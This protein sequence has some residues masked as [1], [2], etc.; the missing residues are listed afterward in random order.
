MRDRILNFVLYQT[1][2]FAVVLSAAGGK[3]WEGSAVGLVLVGVHLYLS[4]ERGPEI[5]MIL[6]IGIMG[7]VVDSA[8][9][10]AGV[11]VFESGYWTYWIVPFW[12]TV[13]WLQFATLFHFVLA[14]LS[15]RYF[16]SAALGGLGGPAAFLTG[17]KLGGVIFPMGTRYSLLILAGVWAG[18]TPA[19]VFIAD[20][21]RPGGGMGSYRLPKRAVEENHSS[22]RGSEYR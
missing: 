1:G 19:C 3:P 9:A 15:G 11:F 14:W 18:V 22:R 16:L 20:R 6:S 5:R 21:F 4:R 12:L 10:F 7:T 8:Q 2:W 17:E 13:M